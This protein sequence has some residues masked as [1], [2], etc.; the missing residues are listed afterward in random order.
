[1]MTNI[2]PT[3]KLIEAADVLKVHPKTVE[4][5]IRYGVIPAA[6]IGRSW[7]MLSTDVLRYVEDEI[8]RQTAERM[9]KPGQGVPL[10]PRKVPAAPHG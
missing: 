5:L 10:K 2:K 4:D 9:R 8:I 1:M 6:K 3:L 7:V